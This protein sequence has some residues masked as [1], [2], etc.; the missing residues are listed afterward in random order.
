[1]SSQDGAAAAP[2]THRRSHA[3]ATHWL[4]ACV[5]SLCVCGHTE[6]S[7]L[8]SLELNTK[9]KRVQ[10]ATFHRVSATPASPA[11]D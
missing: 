11:T 7:L 8:V 2:R 3:W 4:H 5:I 10:S 9:Q 1:M 6:D